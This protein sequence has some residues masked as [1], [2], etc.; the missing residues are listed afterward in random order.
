MNNKTFELKLREGLEK[1]DSQQI[2]QFAWRCAVLTLPCLGCEGNF[3]FW[4]ENYRQKHIYA[5]FEAL[6]ACAYININHKF[7]KPIYP[8]IE[9][10]NKTDN[11]ANSILNFPIENFNHAENRLPIFHTIK[12]IFD[13]ISTSINAH[14]L[15]KETK[16][17]VNAAYFTAMNANDAI[18]E[19]QLD[20]EYVILKCLN[21]ENFIDFQVENMDCYINIWDNFRNALKAEGCNYELYSNVV[22]EL[23]S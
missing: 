3:T 8:Y 22:D 2:S 15:K 17:I 5:I 4:Q 19:N 9:I 10:A 11:L 7:L 6:D 18:Y 1:S 21:I 13:A 23:K 20:F 14:Y 12:A 16:Y